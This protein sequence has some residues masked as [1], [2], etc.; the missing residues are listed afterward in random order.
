V[1]QVLKVVLFAGGVVV[2]AGTVL[3][4]VR[5]TVLPRGVQSRLN[6]QVFSAL[7]V[8]FR[9][10]SGR[11]PTY[12]RRD[13]IMAM[14]GPIGLLLMLTTWL[15]LIIA[16]FT[17]M[18]WA[19]GVHPW[20]IALQFS[21]S[22][23]FTLG[24]TTW[25]SLGPNLL[26]YTEA[27]F[28]LLL[29]TLLITYLPV[30]YTSFQRRETNV[31]LLQVRAGSPPSAVNLLIRYHRIEKFDELGELWR[32]WEL[33]FAD[34]AESHISFPV[35]AYFRSPQPDKSWV[36][37]GGTVLDAAS[38]WASTVEHPRDPD[39]QLL[40][41]AGYIALRQIAEFYS[42]PFDRNPQPTDP[43]SIS[44]YEFDEACRMLAEAGVPLKQDLDAAW[45]AFA[46]W[47]VNYD[48]PLLNLARL[49]EAPLAPWTSDRSPLQ[50]RTS[51]LRRVVKTAKAT[52]RARRSQRRGP[53]A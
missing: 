15:V 13:R 38:L 36:T 42:V 53:Q 4:A 23:I 14:Y 52:S 6:T 41:R 8:V 50:I 51:R 44:R 20:R 34:I 33:W 45:E 9:L 1:E 37:A 22:S 27:G 10:L 2:A 25:K 26:S 30:L 31:T 46:G 32:Q 47:R 43:I 16:A 28:G 11:S 3:S 48:T 17:I 24:T 29:L 19:A 49:T 40:I 7:R 39:A 18:F 21:G 35:L 12:E 5:T